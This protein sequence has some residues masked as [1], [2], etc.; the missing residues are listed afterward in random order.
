M[1]CKKHVPHSLSGPQS[2][3]ASVHGSVGILVNN[4]GAEVAKE[5]PQC[6]RRC[7]HS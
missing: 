2:S 5:V 4:A 3:V 1:N 7:Q 6:L